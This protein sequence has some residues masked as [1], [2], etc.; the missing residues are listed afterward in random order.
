MACQLAAAKH[1]FQAQLHQ[2]AKAHLLAMQHAMGG[3]E[4]GEAVVHG[5]GGHGAA[6]G[7][8]DAPN[9]PGGEGA[10]LHHAHPGFAA[11]VG[12]GGLGFQQELVA[13]HPGHLHRLLNQS[14]VAGATAYGGFV[15][16][17]HRIGDATGQGA[18][19][20]LPNEAVVEHQQVR[21]ARQRHI[22]DEGPLG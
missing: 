2:D 18:L 16:L 6:P 7:P 11:R 17:G 4:L 10:G 1:F 21:A 12:Q 22:A 15:P 13:Q 5:M 19:R 20:G 3:F 8:T 14:V 9:Q